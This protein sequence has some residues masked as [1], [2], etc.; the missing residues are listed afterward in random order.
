MNIQQTCNCFVAK[1]K[2]SPFKFLLSWEIK[3]NSLILIKLTLMP[4]P[5]T[6]VQHRTKEF[7]ASIKIIFS[8][9]WVKRVKKWKRARETDSIWEALWVAGEAM[10]ER[11]NYFQSNFTNENS[12]F[13][14]KY[15]RFDIGAKKVSVS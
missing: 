6:N 9:T 8:I 3:K 13:S 14:W 12:S 11:K 1:L 5:W 4:A 2:F 7:T 10:R 15:L